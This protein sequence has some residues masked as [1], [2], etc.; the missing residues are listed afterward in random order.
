MTTE[1][2]RS[3]SNGEYLSGM[4][5]P[6]MWNKETYFIEYRNFFGKKVTI[7]AEAETK[8]QAERIFNLRMDSSC[9]ILNIKNSNDIAEEIS[10]HLME[11][12]RKSFAETKA[13]MDAKKIINMEEKIKQLEQEVAAYKKI[14]TMAD[15]P[16]IF[17]DNPTLI[18]CASLTH[19]D[20]EL[21]STWVKEYE[22][23]KKGLSLT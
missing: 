17:I 8:E 7:P 13:R 23:K 4:W 10:D 20:I 21:A 22:D 18:E 14:C 9:S 5:Q 11:L 2:R 19:E 3:F 12:V 15:V 16:Q 1:R 6:K